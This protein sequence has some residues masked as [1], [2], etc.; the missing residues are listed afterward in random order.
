MFLFLSVVS[1]GIFYFRA[2]R[3]KLKHPTKTYY[4]SHG[5]V[6]ICFLGAILLSI[7]SY[8]IIKSWCPISEKELPTFFY[9]LNTICS[10]CIPIA[11]FIVYSVKARY[12]IQKKVNQI[13][14]NVVSVTNDLDQIFTEIKVHFKYKSDDD[15]D[16]NGTSPLEDN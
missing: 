12:K 13:N 1:F 9:Y 15:F 10:I 4:P 8:L 14:T 3:F 7:C 5:I 11:H 6:I 2:K 16:I